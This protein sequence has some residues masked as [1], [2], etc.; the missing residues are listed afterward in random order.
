MVRIGARLIVPL[1]RALW[2]ITPGVVRAIGFTLDLMLVALGAVW[3]G[4]PRAT[5]VIANK[6]LDKAV[7]SGVPT[8][9]DRTVYT[10]ARIVAVL[11]IVAGWILLAHLT[12]W[13]TNFIFG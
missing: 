12:V 11:T 3:S 2:F 7:L 4:I 10:I 9:Y 8:I 1:Y 6:T 5:D 13:M